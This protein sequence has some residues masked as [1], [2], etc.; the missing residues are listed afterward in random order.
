MCHSD[1]TSVALSYEKMYCL[2]FINKILNLS[3]NFT[4]KFNTMSLKI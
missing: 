3:V 4:I 2:S 1:Q